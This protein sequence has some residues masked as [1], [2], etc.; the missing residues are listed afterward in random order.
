MNATKE[1]IQ[2]AI[3]LNKKLREKLPRF[4][5]FGDPN[6]DNINAEIRLLE[7][8]L[9]GGLPSMDDFP[10]EAEECHYWLRYPDRSEYLD[11]LRES[12]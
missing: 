6:W 4:S 10:D 8:A 11:T 2:E 12:V 9:D 3:A 1:Q 7:Q 5:A